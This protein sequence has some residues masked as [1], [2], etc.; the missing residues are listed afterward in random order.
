MENEKT[1]QDLAN[2]LWP[3]LVQAGF[4]HGPTWFHRPDGRRLIV[5][6][7]LGS[8]AAQYTSDLTGPEWSR[9]RSCFYGSRV[10]K[11][12]WALRWAA[13]TP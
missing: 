6:R 12:Q 11:L 4:T 13:I 9:A 3:R 10:Y 5:Y 1:I 7:E 8:L 2:I